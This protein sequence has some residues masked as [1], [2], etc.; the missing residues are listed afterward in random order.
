MNRHDN[1]G[2]LGEDDSGEQDFSNVR[3]EMPHFKEKEITS[4]ESAVAD[5]AIILSDRETSVDAREEA[6]NLR[7]DTA[8]SREDA[9]NLR[10]HAAFLREEAARLREVAVGIREGKAQVRE[11]AT[12]S[13]REARLRETRLASGRIKVLQEANARLVVATLEART[14]VEQVENAKTQL[15]HLAHH[16]VLTGL[17]NRILL[18]DRLAQAIELASRQHTALAVLFLDLDR[19]KHINDSLGH[20]VGDKLLQSVARRLLACVRHSDTASRQGGDEFVVLLSNIKQAE[21]AA[22]IAQKILAALTV[23]YV[24]D[25]R[26]LHVSASIGVATYPGDG[27]DAETLLKSADSAMYHAKESGRNNYKFF[28]QDMNVR[29]VQRQSIEASLH[30][31]LERQEF[32]LH[33]QPKIDLHSNMIIGVEALIRWQHPERGLVP[34]SQFVCVAEDCGLILPIGRWVLREGCMQA[35]AWREAGLP[36]VIVAVNTSAREFSA[37]DF[38]ENVRATLEDARLEPRYLELELTESVLMKDAT[39]TN[40]M[41]NALTD[42][43]VKLAIDDFGTGYSSL[44]YLRQFPVD[45]LKIDKSFVSRMT[46]N[47]EDAAIVSAVIGM[48]KSLKLRVIAEGV[49]TAEQRAFLLAQHCDEAQGYYF[50]RPVVAEAFAT[51]LQMGIRPS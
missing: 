31:A 20:V 12:S 28:V 39:V 34:P 30:R 21:N 7:E 44:S 23:P 51:L 6:A 50:S 47:T 11:S 19:F 26:E 27:Q 25:E 43:G 8:Y 36:P 29:A 35:R 4:R 13:E 3:N 14:L 49:E 1:Q 40:P 24:I 10:E 15:D 18:Q 38:M 9:A 37:T 2:T 22:I 5:N 16:D 17:P 32:V 42:L 46:S 45:T 33:Y 48:G 41:L